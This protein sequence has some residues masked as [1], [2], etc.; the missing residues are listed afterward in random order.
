MLCARAP[1][2]CAAA[3]GGG[4]GRGPGAGERRV[5]EPTRVDRPLKVKSHS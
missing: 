4:N 2:A 5:R 1:A 3:A